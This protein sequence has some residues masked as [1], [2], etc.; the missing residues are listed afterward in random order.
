MTVEQTELIDSVS[1]DQAGAICTLGILDDL[2]WDDAHLQLLQDKLNTYLRFIE[3]GEIFV[4]YPAL[5][6]LVEQGLDFAIELRCIY[7]PGDQANLFLESAGNI[8][9]D[10]GYIL[11]V[12]PLGS[13]FASDDADGVL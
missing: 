5:Q 4:Q 7:A 9:R 10:A 2:S 3:S 11:R 8:M 6:E 13:A 12:G 1:L